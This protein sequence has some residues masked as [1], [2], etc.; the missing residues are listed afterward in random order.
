MLP[1]MLSLF[2]ALPS[3]HADIVFVG[4]LVAFDTVLEVADAFL[5]MLAANLLG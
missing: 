3:W 4:V 1:A 2:L 5:D